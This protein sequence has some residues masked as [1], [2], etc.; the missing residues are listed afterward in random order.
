[1]ECVKNN[2][3]DFIANPNICCNFAFMNRISAIIL[4]VSS[5]AVMV[6]CTDKG[7][8]HERLD[9]VNQCNRADTV[10]TEL[11]LA[12]VD[13]LVN[14]FDRHGNSN[15]KMMTH[16]LKGRVHHDMG[17]APIALECYQQATEKADTTS[18][19]CDLH[20][21]AAIYGQMAVLYHGQ[22]LPDDEMS[23]LQM[24]EK[25]AYKNKDTLAVITAYRLRTGVYFHR[26][27]TDSMLQVTN[28]SVE[29][30]RQHGG[31][32]LAAQILIIPISI[33][34]NRG[35]YQKAWEDMQVY[36]KESGFFDEK[37]NVLRGKELYY[38]YKGLYS[39]SQ[40]KNDEAVALFRK[41][42]SGG[43]MEAGYKGLL[44]VYEKKQIPDS[45][46]KY[47]RLYVNAN[48]DFYKGVEQDVI[49]QAS[50]LYNYNRQQRL[51]DE[52]SRKARTGRML[53]AIISLLGIATIVIGYRR[54][55]HK[56]KQKI[57]QLSL[58]Y[59]SSLSQLYTAKDKLRLMNY[60]YE[61]RNRQMES[62]IENLKKDIV[63]AN[64]EKNMLDVNMS[65]LQQRLSELIEDQ[66]E[67]FNQHKEEI[68]DKEME[69]AKWQERAKE[70]D[71]Q[72]VL[73]R[74]MNNEARFKDSVIYKKFEVRSLSKHVI[75]PPDEKDW[76]ALT[77]AFRTHFIRYY[78]FIAQDNHLPI[79]QFRL[80]MLIRLGFNNEQIRILMDKDTQQVYRLKKL[81]NY[82]LFG[83]QDAS[84]L[85]QNLKIY[86]L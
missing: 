48:D 56:A 15:E 59:E 54:I 14:Y 64:Q 23:A 74:G 6:S 37:G 32:N 82:S 3:Y 45:I 50:A 52:N 1:M 70:L 78:A 72:F 18:K 68:R 4:V 55:R 9:Y 2:L 25:Y 39:L 7:A 47:A 69:I 33:Y 42:L 26:N 57:E 31:N 5:L 75:V 46:A 28:R 43:F 67:M 12:T 49:H 66:E 62:E 44:A 13:S 11:W 41:A 77:E 85:E 19:D 81:A 60:D 38:Y 34:L 17:E 29:L 58:D 10:F 24:A 35:E 63:K 40:N 51:A 83:S 53:A 22:L 71:E 65:G 21:L 84:T 30:Y 80:C 79:N 86:Y 8:M 20:T 76:N 27:D 16:Y 73:N 61:I 36:E